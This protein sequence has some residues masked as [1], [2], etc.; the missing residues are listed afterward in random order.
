[1]EWF[2]SVQIKEACHLFPSFDRSVIKYDKICSLQSCG[3]ISSQCTQFRLT[4]TKMLRNWK[5]ST[6]QKSYSDR[7]VHSVQIYLM[8]FFY[9]YGSV[10]SVHFTSWLKLFD[11]ERIFSRDKTSA[12]LNFNSYFEKYWDMMV[13][14]RTHIAR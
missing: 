2:C 5:G 13:C 6:H 11:K 9:S 14:W 12:S 7:A 8:R 10:T 3:N 1:M 4:I